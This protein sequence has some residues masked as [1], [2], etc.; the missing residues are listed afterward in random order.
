MRMPCASVWPHWF[1]S[2]L[3]ILVAYTKKN[4][5]IGSDGRI[6]WNLPSERA[7]F[8]QICSNQR[9]IMGRKSFEEIGHALPYC[10]IVIVSQ[11]MSEDAVPYGCLLARDFS[12]AVRTAGKSGEEILVAGGE[13]IYNH[14]IPLAQKIYATEILA[15]FDGDK[16]FPRLPGGEEAWAKKTVSRCEDSG[17]R[18]DYVT[19]ERALL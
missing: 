19:Y 18:Y 7:R 11:S 16:F 13:E 9:I 10:T 15:D 2:M 5:V 3:S 14:A 4:R 12:E 17:I 8:K 6:P 1:R